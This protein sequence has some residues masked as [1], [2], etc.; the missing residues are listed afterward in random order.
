MPFPETIE[1]L[2]A[3]GYKFSNDAR[4]RGCGASVEWWD[5]PN[6]KKIPMDVDADG[7]CEAHWATCPKAKDFRK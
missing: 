4:C 2:A 1:A 7:N 6:G 5:T 3:A